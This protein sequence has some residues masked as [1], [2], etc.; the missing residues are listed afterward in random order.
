[1]TQ[2]TG[3]ADYFGPL[4]NL[5]A[6]VAGQAH[7]SQILLESSSFSNQYSAAWRMGETVELRHSDVVAFVKPDKQGRLVKLK[8]IEEGKR[9]YSVHCAKLA[10]MRFPPAEGLIGVDTTCVK[11][12]WQSAVRILQ[13][14]GAL[15]SAGSGRNMSINVMGRKVTP[16]AF[17]PPPNATLMPFQSEQHSVYIAAWSC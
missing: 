13:A 4:A 11:S 5:T 9:L 14:S 2:A 3:S 8:G 6:R 17:K 10:D 7:Q 1:V 12:N 16:L 15:S